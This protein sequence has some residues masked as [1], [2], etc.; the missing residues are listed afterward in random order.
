MLARDKA[1]L[2][3]GVNSGEEDALHFSPGGFCGHTSGEQRWKL[4]PDTK[5]RGNTY[6]LR[7]NGKW[8]RVG[9]KDKDG[10]RATIG[11]RRHFHDF[12]F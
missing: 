4:T 12:N 10:E 7:K 9:D 2:L 6:S 3:N 8:I 11:E 1:E 5:G